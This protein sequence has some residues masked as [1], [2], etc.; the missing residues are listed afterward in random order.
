MR[1]A[2]LVAVLGGLG[3]CEDPKVAEQYETHCAPCHRTGAVDAPRKGDAE[4]WAW[5]LERGEDNMFRSLRE[6]R[7]GMPPRGRCVACS[8]EDLRALIQYMLR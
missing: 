1:G 5:R 3:A 4:S 8:D 6:G 7:V 2:I